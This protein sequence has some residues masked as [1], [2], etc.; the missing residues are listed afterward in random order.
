MSTKSIVCG[1]DLGTSTSIIAVYRNGK[2]EIISNEHGENLTPS[3]VSFDDNER[4]I[5]R[6]AKNQ[7]SRNPTNTIYDAKRLI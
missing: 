7:A 2:V 4:T 6:S 3:Y 5:G 1:I